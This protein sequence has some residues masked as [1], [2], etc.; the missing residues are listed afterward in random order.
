MS[1]HDREILELNELCGALI[2]GTLN[3]AQRTRLT[4]LLRNSEAARRYYVRALSQSASLHSY[5]AE[6]HADAPDARGGRRL[7]FPSWIGAALAVAAALVVGFVLW[8]RGGSADRE[9]RSSRPEFVARLTGA[10]ATAWGR[11]REALRPGAYLRRGQRLELRS[12]LAE[13]TFDSG[14]RLVLEGAAS[15]DINSAWDATLRGGTLKASVPPEAIGFRVSNAFVDVLDLGTEF[16]MI[17]DPKRGAEV[18]VNKGEVEAAPRA[19]G[20]T[21]TI[22]LRETEA[23]RFA[24]SGVSDVSDRERKLRL[25]TAPL[26]LERFTPALNYAHWSFDGREAA[27]RVD[28]PL[29]SSGASDLSVLGAEQGSLTRVESAHGEALRFDGERYARASFPG[30]TGS[31][32]RTIAFWVRV[33]EDAPPIDTW[34]I[35]WGTSL[36]KLGYR[37]V[38]IGWNRRP[39]EGALGALRTD[40]GGGHAIASTSLRDGK[41]HHVAVYFAPGDDPDSPVQVK[42]YVDGRLESSTVAPGAVRA[43]AGAADATVADA[44]FLGYRLTGH[45]QEGRRFRG[46]LDELFIAD[47]AL[48]PNEIV[49]LM[50]DNRPPSTAVV[51]NP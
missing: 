18:L 10:K 31:Q 44:V 47:R 22:L 7:S 28:G 36:P 29:A 9:N 34:M 40:F 4:G 23:R 21:E 13:I 17:A 37:P 16:T 11:D 45:K 46:D 20:D 1:L 2:D 38:H 14:A 33:P 5:A 41:W 24:E 42:Q 43:P 3:D 39:A 27:L 6:I 12:G 50:K 15:L 30:I 48:Q 35:A 26:A 51:S 49:A 25:F 19:G 32:P 8:N